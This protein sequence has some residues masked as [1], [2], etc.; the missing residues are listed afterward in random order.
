MPTTQ[1]TIVTPERELYSEEVDQVT[2]PTQTGQI[3]VLPHHIPLVAPLSPGELIIKQGTDVVPLSVAGGFVKVERDSVQVLA[4]GAEHVEEID[5]A[6]AQAAK[7]RAEQLMQQK[8]LD[9]EQYAEISAKIEQE[10]ARVHVARKW[11]RS[12]RARTQ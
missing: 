4:D 7:E 10:L 3:T 6:E 11:R 8:Q 12:E 9:N 1:L 2:L 5:E